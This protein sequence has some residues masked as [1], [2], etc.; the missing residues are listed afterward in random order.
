[1][2][3][4]SAPCA[5][6][7]NVNA[8][9]AEPSTHCCSMREPRAGA[10]L[11][12]GRVARTCRSSRSRSTRRASNV[13]RQ[14]ARGIS[15]T[16]R[17][18]LTRC[19]STRERARVPPRLVDEARQIDSRRRARVLMRS[20]TFLLNAAVSAERIVVPEQQV[21]LRLHEVRAEQQR[22]R[23]GGARARICRS[24]RRRVLRIEVADVRAE[25][26]HQLGARAP[27]A[28]DRAQAGFV[29]GLVRR[30]RARRRSV[31]SVAPPRSSA[32]ADTSIRC[33]AGGPARRPPHRPGSAS[34]SPL[35]PPSSMNEAPRRRR[36]RSR[37]RVA[38]EQR[39]LAARDAVPRQTADRLEERRPERVVEPARR[40]PLGARE[41][42][43]PRRPRRR[44]RAARRGSDARSGTWRRHRDSGAGTSCGSC[45]AR[46]A[47]GV[48]GDAPFSTKCAAVEEVG[49]VLGIGR[50]RARSPGMARTTW[51]STPSR[52]RSRSCTPNA[53]AP[54]GYEPDRHRI[55]V[56]RR[57]SCRASIVRRR[58]APRQRL[59]AS[60]GCAERRAVV[61]RLGHEP[62]AAP[63]GERRR[64]RHG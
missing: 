22:G 32:R 54:D 18:V 51:T 6:R 34:F 26:E 27:A 49:G 28:R 61:L 24:K 31:P 52:C 40:Q 46:S 14:R 12:R 25:E 30:R 23:P 39:R 4:A 8:K 36:P 53:L 2:P 55:P 56:P 47:A 17:R 13:T 44:R 38:R 7:N 64:P 15:M 20:S 50:H 58:V 19:I 59:F 48:A 41:Q 62:V 45:G 37:A 16:W 29:G 35:P 10:H 57:R 1:M 43:S 21:A 60:A 3:A 11:R 63:A 33:T 5:R 42:A 9:P